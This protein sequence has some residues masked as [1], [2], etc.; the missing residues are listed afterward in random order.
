MVLFACYVKY[1]VPVLLGDK[2]EATLVLSLV[3]QDVFPRCN[4]TKLQGTFL[5]LLC[6][7]LSLMSRACSETSCLSPD[8]LGSFTVFCGYLSLS[9]HRNHFGVAIS[10]IWATC[11]WPRLQ[12]CFQWASVKSILKEVDLQKC[13]GVGGMVSARFVLDFCQRVTVVEAWL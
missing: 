6:E 10:P 13:T 2:S 7:M 11:I 8:Y 12:C 4:S 5:V 3:R 1:F 9:L